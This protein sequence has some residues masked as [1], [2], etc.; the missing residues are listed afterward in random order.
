MPTDQELVAICDQDYYEAIHNQEHVQWGVW[1]DNIAK[2]IGLNDDLFRR[3]HAKIYHFYNDKTSW[4]F[5]GSVNFSHKAFGYHLSSSNIETGFF[6]KNTKVEQLLKPLSNEHEI[7]QFNPP[8]GDQSGGNE[9]DSKQSLPEIHLAYDW[10]EKRLS[11]KTAVH[12][13]L[14]IEIMN[15]EGQ[16]VIS[17]WSLD[18]QPCEYNLSDEDTRSIELL[19]KHGSLVKVG[20]RDLSSEL[21]FDTHTVLLQQTS[22]THKPLDLP[23][24][25]T[26]QIIAIYAGMSAERRQMIIVNDQ[27][28][29][30]V[31][32]GMAG[33][34]STTD[35]SLTSEQFFCEYAELFYAFNTFNKR[36]H[37]ELE[38]GNEEQLDYY[39]TGTGLDSIPEL[40]SQA[41]SHDD[42]NSTTITS[43]LILLLTKE[44][45]QYPAFSSRQ[46]VVK[47][48]TD[49]N[50]QI[51]LIKA[52]PWIK[53][54]NDSPENRKKFFLWFEQQFYANY[55]EQLND[56]V[57]VVNGSH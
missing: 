41:S 34:I 25:T 56:E 40:I 23:N 19:L 18:E 26:A 33:E 10:K 54:D 8:K 17:A 27:I 15:S 7:T 44:L 2:S 55:Q 29:H 20:G 42:E 21:L 43:Y 24:L 32:N 31:L 1:Q 11:G 37:A 5:I 57:G 35:D 12:Q 30:L 14:L 52:S 6:I 28:K 13:H 49:I 46:H 45:Y 3:L 36:L 22:W 4:L 16:Q 51:D 53:L 38:R 47:Y 48:L 39:L 9:D 50:K